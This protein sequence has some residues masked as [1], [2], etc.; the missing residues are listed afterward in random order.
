MLK[1]P[2]KGS[3]EREKKEDEEVLVI[4]GTEFERDLSVKFGVHIS[5]KDNVAWDQEILESL[6][7]FL[8]SGTK[9]WVIS[10]FSKRS[11]K[12]ENLQETANPSQ[13]AAIAN[14][15]LITLFF[16]KFGLEKDGYKNKSHSHTYIHTQ[17]HKHTLGHGMGP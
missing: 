12:L 4:E 1:R 15:S 8:S 3:N 13:G 10:S 9:D 16:L 17:H 11:Q 7:R 2:K 14:P 6:T 5:D